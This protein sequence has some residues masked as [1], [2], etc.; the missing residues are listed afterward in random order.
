MEQSIKYRWW[1]RRDITKA[2]LKIELMQEEKAKQRGYGE[3]PM[4]SG[5]GKK[6][7]RNTQEK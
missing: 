6:I 3:S 2:S 1:K 7:K 4:G 5:G